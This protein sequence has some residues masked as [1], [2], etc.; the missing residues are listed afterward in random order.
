MTNRK[1]K[2]S[3]RCSLTAAGG[4]EH[5]QKG[6]TVKS[7]KKSKSLLTSKD[8]ETFYCFK[9]YTANRD[10]HYVTT[11][12][13]KEAMAVID[14][15]TPDEHE[16]SFVRFRYNVQANR[17]E[18]VADYCDDDGWVRP[19]PKLEKELRLLVE[20]KGSQPHG[21]FFVLSDLMKRKKPLAGERV[22]FT[23]ETVPHNAKQPTDLPV[24]ASALLDETYPTPD[25][26]TQAFKWVSEKG[27]NA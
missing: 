1:K 12:E 23:V 7:R 14:R 21:A 24:Q 5:R 16:T 2:R 18:E 20:Q 10:F 19:E 8:A 3:D 4:G 25:L 9:D 27:G 13:E 6:L 22:S 11:L 26:R 15:A 17:C